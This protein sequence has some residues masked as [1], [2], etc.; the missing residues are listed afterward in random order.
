MILAIRF[1]IILLRGSLSIGGIVGETWPHVRCML[2]IQRGLGIG[3]H[4]YMKLRGVNRDSSICQFSL[5]TSKV[6]CSFLVVNS[7]EIKTVERSDEFQHSHTTF[8]ERKRLSI[9]RSSA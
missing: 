4:Y 5:D 2:A 7:A 6:D 1:P 3:F 9:F 8:Q